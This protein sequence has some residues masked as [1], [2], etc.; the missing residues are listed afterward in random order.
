[1]ETASPLSPF[2]IMCWGS[3]WAASALIRALPPQL[4]H[5]ALAPPK[6]PLI[7]SLLALLPSLP[8]HKAT[9]EGRAGVILLSQWQGPGLPAVHDLPSWGS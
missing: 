8:P 7:Y 3:A 5:T 4:G 2:L 6:W 9:T 1:M